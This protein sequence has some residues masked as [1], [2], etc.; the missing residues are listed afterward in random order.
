M[1]TGQRVQLADREHDLALEVAAGGTFRCPNSWLRDFVT[2]A[3]HYRGVTEAMVRAIEASESALHAS[4]VHMRAAGTRLLV[5]AQHAGAARTDL[6][7]A[8]VFAPA[9]SLAS[10]GA[11]PALARRLYHPID[12][13]VSAVVTG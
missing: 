8:D 7:G 1:L 10:I 9:A 4:G 2:C 13:V 12:V 11:Q 3:H 5:R 6:D